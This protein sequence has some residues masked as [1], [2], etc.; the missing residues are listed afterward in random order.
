MS[1]KNYERLQAPDGRLVDVPMWKVKDCL[2]AGWR[3]PVIADSRPALHST[4]VDRHKG[5]PAL[6]VATGPSSSLVRAYE[7]RGACNRIG[8]VTWSCN[9]VWRVCGGEAF[10]SVTY[11]VVLDDVYWHVHREQIGAYMR[12]YP[13]T[14]PVLAFELHEPVAYQR[15]GIDMFNLPK[16]GTPYQPNA[17]FHGNSSG[18]AALQMALHC[19]CDPIYLIGHDLTATPKQ[20]HGFG[21]R[22][23]E[24]LNNGYPQGK[25][26]VDGYNLAAEHARSLGRTIVN[27]SPISKLTCFTSGDVREFVKAK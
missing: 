25:M 16:P 17:Y 19:G 27:L 14:L 3:M 9:D 2:A 13:G 20:T 22:S 6:I 21:V 11:H 18:C 23:G 24:E 7:L 4:T 5:K 8:A 12:N 10:P 26:M 1:E 15:I